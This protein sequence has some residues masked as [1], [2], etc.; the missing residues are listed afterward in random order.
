[1]KVAL[2]GAGNIAL[3]HGP[4]IKAIK[5]AHI[6]G[7]CDTNPL[8]A[9][10]TAEELGADDFYTD[11][12]TM[13][14]KSN[15]DVVHILT[16]PETHCALSILAMQHGCNV[17]VEKPMASSTE[18]ANEMLAAAE[19]NNVK[20]CAG[21][22]MAFD[23]LTRKVVALVAEGKIGNVISVET[24]F[25]FDTHRYAAV[26]ADGAELTHWIYRLNGGPLQDLL[27]HPA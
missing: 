26:H 1:M 8:R 10:S 24:S 21:H 27:P 18:E 4:A 19:K 6:V 11:A 7:V 23:A 5:D 2:I 14:V 16:P 17:L 3:A 15:P 12:E 20:I 22:N 25:R 9:Q 13:L